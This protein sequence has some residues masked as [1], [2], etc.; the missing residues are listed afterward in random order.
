MLIFLQHFL[1]EYFCNLVS[2][3]FS[4]QCD[5][6]SGKNDTCSFFM[7]V[8]HHISHV[9]SVIVLSVQR[10]PEMSFSFSLYVCKSII[11]MICLVKCGSGGKKACHMSCYHHNFL[12]VL[13]K[14]K[15]NIE[16]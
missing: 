14:F 16:E 2:S 11:E 1:E 13:R 4:K 6:K 15:R 9:Q 7:N 8:C 12:F 3:S 10:A 5:K